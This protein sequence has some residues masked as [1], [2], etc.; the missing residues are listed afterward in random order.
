MLII[1]SNNAAASNNIQ[2]SGNLIANAKEADLILLGVKDV[3]ALSTWGRARLKRLENRLSAYAAIN[4]RVFPAQLDGKKILFAGSVDGKLLRA[5][6]A[7]GLEIYYA[8]VVHTEQ[9]GG[10]QI[11]YVGAEKER[12]GIEL[13]AWSGDNPKE[14]ADVFLADDSALAALAVQH[15]VNITANLSVQELKKFL[16][17]YLGSAE[18]PG[19]VVS[20]VPIDGDDRLYSKILV[21]LETGVVTTNRE[22]APIR[23]RSFIY[24]IGMVEG[25]SN[26]ALLTLYLAG[27]AG[28]SIK[29]I[30]G[31]LAF[32][33]QCWEEEDTYGMVMTNRQRLRHVRHHSAAVMKIQ[34]SST[35]PFFYLEN[36]NNVE[37]IAWA[38]EAC[39][40][41]GLPYFLDKYGAKRIVVGSGI[42]GLYLGVVN[43]EHGN[44]QAIRFITET[45]KEKK[46]PNRPWNSTAIVA[47]E[48][49]PGTPGYRPY[50]I[51]KMRVRAEGNGEVLLLE[52][53]GDKR[54]TVFTNKL[55]AVNGSGVGDVGPIP[56]SYSLSKSLRG[57]FNSVNL[58]ENQSLDDAAAEIEQALKELVAKGAVIK[59]QGSDGFRSVF[60]YNGISLLSFNGYNQE[61]IIDSDCKFEVKRT[62]TS[63]S[64]LISL[65]AK[66]AASFHEIKFRGLGI[67]AVLK[68]TEMEL[69][70]ISG[71]QVNYEVHMGLE[72]QKGHAW[73]LPMFCEAMCQTEDQFCVLDVSKGVIEIPHLDH[74]VDLKANQSLLTQ[75]ISDNTDEF[76]TTDYVCRDEFEYVLSLNNFDGVIEWEVDPDDEDLIIV[77]EKVVG[78]AGYFTGNVEVS[79]RPENS[80]VNASYMTIEQLA[81]LSINAPA[82]AKFLA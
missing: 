47:E 19:N 59:A 56:F 51:S 61:L 23:Y 46:L 13:R 78:I 71:E 16:T 32:L 25:Q 72:C 18:E 26:L 11:D 39:H 48:G 17:L 42:A 70:T 81:G 57:S 30:N 77:R 69:E 14:S 55:F 54:F 40:A 82:L 33:T 3:A 68:R 22:Y 35:L 60:E 80:S 2:V 53:L 74:T 31:I 58:K 24:P 43:D 8:K 76:I 15:L 5:C 10:I 63:D 9:N 1:G 52:E 27:N 36:F 41:A 4:S 21:D 20:I 37:G 44:A 38:G 7:E 12:H 62:P 73:V 49:I 64:L 28:R 6:H 34:P 75:W 79:T 29:D 65:Q 66:L 50:T 45:A 67:K